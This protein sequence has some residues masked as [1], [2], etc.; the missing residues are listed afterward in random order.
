MKTGSIFGFIPGNDLGGIRVVIWWDSRDTRLERN[1]DAFTGNFGWWN[2]SFHYQHSLV[3]RTMLSL[4]H[5]INVTER[6]LGRDSQ[7]L[8]QASAVSV[9]WL[10][11]WKGLWI[12]TASGF[13]TRYP[14]RSKLLWKMWIA[15]KAVT[16][17]KSTNCRH[18][19]EKPYMCVFICCGLHNW[20]V[21]Q[22]HIEA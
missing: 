16:L 18:G 8:T 13:L 9:M 2:R 12:P 19:H 4:Q 14:E 1:N 7:W 11:G 22:A 15:G 6:C 10:Q 5:T 3:W 20:R 17:D 21:A